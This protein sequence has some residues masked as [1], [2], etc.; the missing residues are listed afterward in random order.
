M[1]LQARPGRMFTKQR[2]WDC[3]T[4]GEACSS[5]HTQPKWRGDACTCYSDHDMAASTRW[6]CE[7]WAWVQESGWE[8]NTNKSWR[9]PPILSWKPTLEGH[10][11]CSPPAPM[12]DAGRMKPRCHC[13][14]HCHASQ[15]PGVTSIGST[16]RPSSLKFSYPSLLNE[17]PEMPPRMPPTCR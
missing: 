5:S 12:T 17:S 8:W 2:R 6:R 7:C 13:H 9:C 14:C 16:R 15:A 4:Q 10:V 11:W 3:V 1:L